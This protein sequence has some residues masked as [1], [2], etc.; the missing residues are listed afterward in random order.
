M[1]AG[2]A[3]LLTP[4]GRGAIASLLVEHAV[5]L[6]DQHHLFTAINNQ[7]LARQPL[8][9]ICPGLWGHKDGRQSTEQIVACRT[10]ETR[11]E[12]HCHGGPAATRRILE[13]LAEMGIDRCEWTELVGLAE[14]PSHSQL[15]VELDQ[16]L[17]ATTTW[18]AAA[19][20]LDQRS[21]LLVKTLGRLATVDWAARQQ[22]ADELAGLL[23]WTDLG[24]HLAR[25]WSVVLA[26]PPNVG[27]SSL[28]NALLGY[29][30]A[31]VWDQPGTTRDVVTGSTAL[32]GWAIHLS[33]TA[34]LRTTRDQLEAAGVDHARQRL[35]TAE[36]VVLVMDRS[37]RLDDQ[38][39][40]L[41]AEHPSAL[42]VANKIDLDDAVDEFIPATALPVSALTGEGV[43]ELA[44]AILERLLPR[45]P[46][47]GTAIPISSRLVKHLQQA[48][49]AI[50]E[51][52]EPAYRA[53]TDACLR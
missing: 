15:G 6:I 17:A 10:S 21:G 26:G 30:R 5:N 25:P 27:K 41:L 1:T 8:N 18:Q 47:P 20:L 43:A 46:E 51:N 39:R 19:V 48:E 9:R 24:L 22:V 45:R 34:G 4:A 38:T 12:L 53:A 37:S 42:V 31:I 52:D 13:D 40:A 23:E 14:E 50:H 2:R 3:A 36:L 35:A 28:L 44:D 7:P 33:D 16:A 49:E 32:D 11:I 29:G